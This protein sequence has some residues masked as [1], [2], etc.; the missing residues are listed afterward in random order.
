[1]KF[2]SI[3]QDA[4]TRQ[5]EYQWAEIIQ[6][7]DEVKGMTLILIQKM[8]TA[9]HEYGPLMEEGGLSDDP[10]ILQF[11]R[12]R[13]LARIDTVMSTLRV[14]GLAEIEGAGKLAACREEV[15]SMT[16]VSLLKTLPEQIHQISHLLVDNLQLTSR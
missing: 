14:N 15:Q 9:F 5:E 12:R 1:M 13:L 6:Q 7:G 11:I 3:Q 4:H 2:T 10:T 8:C 16:S